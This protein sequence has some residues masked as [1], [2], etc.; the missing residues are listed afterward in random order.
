MSLRNLTWPQVV[1]CVALLAAVIGTYKL[2]GEI[3]AGVMLV[4][5]SVITFLLGRP[6]PEPPG[7]Q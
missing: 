4:F 5:S 2:F 7:D 6:A 3:P 1:V